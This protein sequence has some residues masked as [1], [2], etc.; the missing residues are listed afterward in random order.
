LNNAVPII[1][2][3]VQS[4]PKVKKEH[5]MKPII[6][7][8]SALA[9]SAGL[10]L[11]GSAATAGDSK[12]TYKQNG[13]TWSTSNNISVFA[14]RTRDRSYSEHRHG[15][16]FGSPLHGSYGRQGIYTKPVH[17]ALNTNNRRS[18]KHVNVGRN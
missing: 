12:I 14:S 16:H 3:E 2:L 15:G 4:N 10:A 1:R 13:V 7:V 8:F 17:D 5:E 11:T 18:K 6:A 9:L